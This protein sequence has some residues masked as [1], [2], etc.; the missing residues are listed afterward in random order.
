MEKT[1]YT[2]LQ[3]FLLYLSDENFH[4]NVKMSVPV[5]VE[6]AFY[7]KVTFGCKSPRNFRE[8]INQNTQK[9]DAF[10]Q[11]RVSHYCLKQSPSETHL[12]LDL[13]EERE[14]GW[15]SL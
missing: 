8:N 4:E 15:M 11:R 14:E 6:N 10:L 2:A 3:F 13:L 1:V 9:F 7:T 12:G 5:V